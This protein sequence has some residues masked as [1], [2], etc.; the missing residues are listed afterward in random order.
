LFR[1]SV[2][3][4]YLVSGLYMSPV[5]CLEKSHEQRAGPRH[6]GNQR[7]DRGGAKATLHVRRTRGDRLRLADHALAHSR[8]PA[9]GSIACVGEARL[10]GLPLPTAK[11]RTPFLHRPRIRP[12]SRGF[13]FGRKCC[14]G[15]SA[16]MTKEIPTN[17]KAVLR[18]A[19]G[20]ASATALLETIVYWCTRKNGGVEYQ[21]RLWSYRQ[22][23]DWI[24]LTGLP[25]STGKRA[26]ARLCRG[27]LHPDR[28]AEARPFRHPSAHNARRL[29]R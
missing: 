24:E 26:W 22:Q 6:A 29:D 8:R 3:L 13:G 9:S 5:Q 12:Q 16:V 19:V 2:I 18:K 28:N 25:E 15:A 21:G 4:T 23:K 1:A 7:G 10:A 17:V 11:T 14:F 27:R 20:N